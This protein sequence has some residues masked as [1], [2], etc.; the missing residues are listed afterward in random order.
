MPS[1]FFFKRIFPN[2]DNKLFQA[3]SYEF[4]YICSRP[5]YFT[6]SSGVETTLDAGTPT[7]LNDCFIEKTPNPP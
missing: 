1:S 6:D 5:K 4:I 2:F 3:L 7:M